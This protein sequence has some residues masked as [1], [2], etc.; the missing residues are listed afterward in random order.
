MQWKASEMCFGIII[1]IS[2]HCKR[3]LNEDEKKTIFFGDSVSHA[4]FI[5]C[6]ECVPEAIKKHNFVII[7]SSLVQNQIW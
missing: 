4:S 7:L 1:S 2:I 5:R 3:R 6:I